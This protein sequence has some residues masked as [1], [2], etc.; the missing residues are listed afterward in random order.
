MNDASKFETQD[1]IVM[2]N[3]SSCCAA[4][5]HYNEE[6]WLYDYKSSKYISQLIKVIILLL[7]TSTSF[8]FQQVT[9]VLGF[10][11]LLLS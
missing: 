7:I 2:F 1:I 5:K 6:L 3:L 4:N 10:Y 8:V 9:F 11:Y